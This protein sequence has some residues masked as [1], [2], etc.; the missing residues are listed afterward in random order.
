MQVEKEATISGS[1][2]ECDTLICQFEQNRLPL[3]AGCDMEGS[4]EAQVTGVLNNI[5]ESV[6]K[7]GACP[8]I[9][10]LPHFSLRRDALLHPKLSSQHLA[11]RGRALSLVLSEEQHRSMLQACM[12]P[13]AKVATPPRMDSLRESLLLGQVIH[14]EGR[15]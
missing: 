15:C 11:I 6:S 9:S 12:T 8:C 1:Y 10:V 13:K 2:G 4:L 3:T 7:V 5:R 14:H